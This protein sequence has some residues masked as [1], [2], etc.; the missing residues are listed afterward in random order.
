MIPRIL[1]EKLT[2]SARRWFSVREASFIIV[3]LRPHYKNFG[4]RLIKT[5]K[6]YSLD[7]GLLCFLLRIQGPDE[8]YFWRDSGGHEI[9]ILIDRGKALI[10][11]E[12]KSAQT[13]AD[14]FFDGFKHWLKLA[15][16]GNGQS[17]L[18][19]GGDRAAMRAGT[20]VYPWFTLYMIARVP[21]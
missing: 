5:P 7:T 12:I 2:E 4:K 21:R 17:A 11:V 6:L 20:A 8:L 19:Y 9:D 16:K 3:L 15:G 18:V 10:P 13:I 14:D 1:A